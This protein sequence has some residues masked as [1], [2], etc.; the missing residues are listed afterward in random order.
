MAETA[1][2]QRCFVV[3]TAPRRPGRSPTFC[4]FPPPP[5]AASSVSFE[6]L[7]P[8]C[9]KCL[10]EFLSSSSVLLT[11]ELTDKNSQAET[12]LLRLSPP[13]TTGLRRQLEESTEN[14]STIEEETVFSRNN[15]P[16]PRFGL[17][18][19]CHYGGRANVVRMTLEVGHEEEESCGNGALLLSP[20][21]V[22]ITICPTARSTDLDMNRLVGLSGMKNLDQFRSSLSGSVSGAV[23]TYS[24]SGPSGSFANLKLTAEILVK[25][26]ASA[27]TDLELAIREIIWS[28][29]L[30][31]QNNKMKKLTENIHALEEKL[32]NAFNENA[33]LRVKQKEDEKLWKGLESKFTSTKTLCN[34]LTETLQHLASQVHDAEKD[35]EFFEDKLSTNASTIDN[36]HDQMKTLSLKLESSEE[37]VRNCEKEFQELSIEKDEAEKSFRN[38]QHKSANLIYE[39]VRLALNSDTTIKHLEATITADRLGMESLNSKLEDLHCELRFKEDDL[40]HLRISEEMLE[41][42]K[43]DLLTSNKEFASKLDKA[44]QEIRNLE[45]FAN[46]RAAKLNELDKQSLAFSDMVVQ[47]NSLYDSC[48]KL[49]QEEKDLGSQ[50]AKKQY[51]QLHSMTLHVT[52][53][54]NALQVVNKE[55][56]NTII[57]LRKGQE[58]AM[59]QHAEECRL[60]EERVRRLESEAESLLS[61]KSE[62]ELLLNKSGGEIKTLSESL[63]LSESKM[64][65]LLLKISALESE[66]KDSTEKLQEEIQKKLE[67]VES[68]QEEIDKHEQH[69]DSL[70]KQVGQVQTTLE[71]KEQLVLRSMDREKELED[72]KA[73]LQAALVDAESKLSEAKM[74]YDSMLESKQLELSRHLKELSQR[75]DQA[76]N[77]IRRKFEVEKLESVTVE[78][79]KADKAVQELERKCDQ[80]LAEH[81]EESQQYLMRIQEEHAALITCIQQEHSTKELNLKYNHSDELKRVQLQAEN[82]LREKTTLLRNEHEVQLRALK[83]QHEDECRKLQE[84]LDIQKSK[85][86]KQR[87]LLQLQWKVMSDKP[88]EDQEVNSKK[89]R[90]IAPPASF[91]VC[92]SPLYR[93]DLDWV[94]NCIIGTLSNSSA[95]TPSEDASEGLSSIENHSVSSTK[96][97]NSEGGRRS[98]RAPVS[99]ENEQK[100]SPYLK[101]TQTP[102]STLLKKVE[103]VNT[104]SVM[105]IPKHSR[106][107][108]HREYEVETSNGRTITKRRKTKSTVMFE[109]PT[110]CKKGTPK[111]TTPRDVCKGMK[112]GNPHPS[113][114]GDL[115]SEGSL[116]PYADDPYAFD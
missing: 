13:K 96:V 62:M 111:V 76:I 109:D 95:L 104:G 48:F 85:E 73:E 1:P 8:S 94:Y 56:N 50:C 105:S 23:K 87:A 14:T 116:N 15:P 64:Q 69:R 68:L 21:T 34:Q 24:N 4:F 53:E 51:D 59:V 17:E 36:L 12:L 101:A 49:V 82:E 91:A 80:K 112:G 84:E 38:E 113:N 42:E 28:V 54:K 92:L 31:M 26:Q 7:P 60:A 6:L 41:K 33:K 106:K 98:Q 72:Q 97:R 102:V 52:S 66:S 40:K 93:R 86:D 78:K 37:T 10:V 32:Q 46:L 18:F 63:I 108:T 25:E 74:Q 39:K 114:I 61:R 81:K 107:V 67:E 89:V 44:L 110:K 83:C 27:K 45:E 16:N 90:Q 22:F 65:D 75:N 35:K 55:L 57:E 2:D 70:E 3:F 100:D 115:F 71:E 9:T 79:E 77:D 103:K 30:K 20:H 29:V 47:L 88:P 99:V 5:T 19:V 11:D 43:S 58:F